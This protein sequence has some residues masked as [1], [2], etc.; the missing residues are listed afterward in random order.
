MAIKPFRFLLTRLKEGELLTFAERITFGA[1][2]AASRGS[3]ATNLDS[4]QSAI[5]L[6]LVMVHTFGHHTA[7]AAISLFFVLIHVRNLL[8]IIC[9]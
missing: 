5:V 1:S 9:A 4:A 6:C 3:A 2:T 8:F 7:D